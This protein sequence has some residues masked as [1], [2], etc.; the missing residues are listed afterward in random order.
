MGGKSFC[1]TE[2]LRESALSRSRHLGTPLGP[3]ASQRPPP[4][5]LSPWQPPSPAA[6]AGSWGVGPPTP[7][8]QPL[9]LGLG[10]KPE[11]PLRGGWALQGSP[12]R[13][14]PCPRRGRAGEPRAQWERPAGTRPLA[15]RLGR[16]KGARNTAQGRHGLG[17]P[18]SLKEQCWG[19]LGTTHRYTRLQS[20]SPRTHVKGPGRDET[21]R[22]LHWVPAPRGRLGPD[23]RSRGLV[24]ESFVRTPAGCGLRGQAGARATR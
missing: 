8:T 16:G 4:G 17:S 7:Q 3:V 22:T 2:Y 13:R 10:V 23:G 14:A 19:R 1:G 6:S 21:S 24:S 12:I 11:G 15:C 9:W 5:C 18:R 20:A